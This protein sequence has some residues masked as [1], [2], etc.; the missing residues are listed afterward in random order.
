MEHAQNQVSSKHALQPQNT[1]RLE[2]VGEKWPSC[3]R[4]RVVG[5]GFLPPSA[6]PSMGAAGV[7]DQNTGK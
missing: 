1:V 6:Y 5:G 4:L 2:R 7:G 3:S